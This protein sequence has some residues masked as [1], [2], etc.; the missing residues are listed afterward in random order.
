[1][2]KS[3]IAKFYWLRKNVSTNNYDEIHKKNQNHTQIQSI[4]FWRK[5][6]S[7]KKNNGENVQNGGQKTEYRKVI[8]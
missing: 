2:Q 8:K 7:D 6:D 1:M 4:Q 5:N 3:Q